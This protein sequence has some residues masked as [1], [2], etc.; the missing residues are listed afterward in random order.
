[1]PVVRAAETTVHEMHDARFTPLIRPAIGS[2]ELCVWRLEIAAGTIGVEH[3]ILREEAF[4]LL[5]G[6]V[7]LTV[8][9]ESSALEPGDAAVAPAESAIRLDNPGED[10][11][12]LMVIAPVGFAGELADGTRITPPWVS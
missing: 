3:R 12:T 4:V 11:A 7:T 8:D 5:G 1:M 6:A 10:P 2:K 9:G